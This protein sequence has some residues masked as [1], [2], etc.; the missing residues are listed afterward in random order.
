MQ[1]TAIIIVSYNTCYMM[2]ENIESIRATLEKGT[3]HIYVVDNASTDGIADWLKTE[4]MDSDDLSVACNS[5]NIGFPVA[6]N[7]GYRMVIEAGDIE[8]DIFLLNNDTR[9]CE[10]SLVNLQEALYSSDNIGAVGSISNYAGNN[11]QV[12]INFPLPYKYVEYGNNNNTKFNGNIK[13]EE[14]VRLSGFA[15][16]IKRKVWED[17]G[18]MDERFT[19]GYFED[20]D[21]SIKIQRLGKKL[22]LC[23]NSFI[24][25]AGSQSFSKLD[26]I[27]DLLVNNYAVFVKKYGFEILDYV[28]PNIEQINKIAYK[29][30]EAFTFLNL[31][32]GLGAQ[33]KYVNSKYKNVV[34]YGVETNNTLYEISKCTN[35]VYDSIS[36]LLDNNSDIKID[37][38]Y[39]TDESLPL[40]SENEIQAV[41]A[42]CSENCLIIPNNVID[43]SKIKLVIWDLDNTFWSGVL[44]EGD[45]AIDD[46]NIT[47]IKTLVDNGIMCSISSKNDE[48]TVL[49]KLSELGIEDYFVFNNINWDDKGEQIKQK[50]LD[51]NLRAE[52]TLFIDDELRNLEEVDFINEGIIA[53]DPQIIP[54]LIN[55]VSS[56]GGTDLEH[57]RLNQYKILEE[58]RDVE[59]SS[60]S[61]E[62]FLYDSEIYIEISGDC[63]SEIDRITELVV[64]SNQLNF[65]KIRDTKETIADL[66]S[67]N[68]IEKGII[69][70][71]D[72]FGD[73]GLIG[74]YCFDN[75]GLLRHFLFSCRVLG[76]GIEQ[77][78]YSMLGYPEINVSAPV[79]VTL[80][81]TETCNWI[82]TNLDEALK[83]QNKKDNE[84]GI[85]VL[86]KGPC[87]LDAV[88]SYLQG[89]N[90]TT[91]FNYVNDLG[92]VTTGQNHSVHI[93]ESSKYSKDEI[94]EYIKGVPFI[95][96]G[97]F[98]TSL[99]TEEYDVICLSLLPD[100]EAGLYRNKKTGFRIAFGSKNFDLTDTENIDGFINGSLQ[101]HGFS[102]TEEIIKSFSDEWE[103]EKYTPVEE[104]IKNLEHIYS[105]VPGNPDFILLLGSEIEYE[106]DNREFANLADRHR[107]VNSAIK[108]YA[109]EKERIRCIETT[110]YIKSQDD[111]ID[112]INHFSRNVY[113]DIATDVVASINDRVLA[114][115]RAKEPEKY[116]ALIMTVPNDY[117]R[118]EHLYKR[119]ISDL[120]AR[121]VR[122]IGNSEVGELVRKSGFGYKLTFTNENNILPFDDVHAV[123]K[124]A[125]SEIL[126]GR[127]LPRGITGWY[128]QQF[129]K[130]A[131]SK[132]CK[133]DYYLVWDGDTVPC[134]YFSMFKEGTNKPYFDLKSEYHEDYFIT[135]SKLLP[136]MG[137]VIRKSFISEHMLMNK[138][139]ML[140]LIDT[141]EANGNLKGETF[142]EKIIYAIEPEKLMS[143]SF[144]EFETYG[145]F[146]A[147]KHMDAY[148]LREWHSFRYGG[149]FFDSKT[150]DDE[151]FRWLSRDFGAISFEKDH[152]VREDH[153]NLFDNKEYQAKLSARQMLEAAQEEFLGDSFIETWEPILEGDIDNRKKLLFCIGI[154]ELFENENRI[155]SVVSGKLRVLNGHTNDIKVTVRLYP[156]NIEQWKETNACITEMVIRKAGKNLDVTTP[157]DELVSK[158]EAYYGGPSPYLYRF[159][160][161]D[162]PVMM[163]NTEVS[164]YE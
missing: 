52:N 47:L 129:L 155:V 138:E 142:Y 131:Y 103:F 139:Y 11:Q 128:Y 145:T 121:R 28:Y 93:V 19:P 152:E 56:L 151:D 6:C 85:K 23:N 51:M 7:Q 25:H 71:K 83:N 9:L 49:E 163:W 154:N 29:S 27:D 60:S 150:I 137:K 148:Q 54:E 40:Y 135:L 127:E 91:E 114:M 68:H 115:S 21:L 125:L 84:N 95:T 111:Y 22:L 67:D 76:M 2:Q 113:Y 161:L 158:N 65:T 58:K 156:N 107:E 64:R 80:N 43:F 38:I 159:M 146:V 79:A 136:G 82:R 30:D 123:M 149:D 144:S 119:L 133:D 120:P 26:N 130:M 66:I 53:S 69:R 18:G 90:I 126:N 15:M 10:K 41:I 122:F 44:S 74:F 1:K 96:Q 50:I 24:Y 108:K 134:K 37:V 147:I 116:D 20:D 4:S 89:G 55:Y 13:W 77:K 57:K 162:K 100:C 105:N 48:K 59:K 78:I 5:D 81:N 73:Y 143:N 3:Y 104:I 39:A 34:S 35:N 42:R 109:S 101:N 94:S 110:K 75:S 46:N 141:I 62:Q 112:C 102:F 36:A 164:N 86:L 98:G 140:E 88:G 160:M 14:R 118:V 12:D 132:V 72:K 70:A 106:G 124:D 16:L 31:G 8:S 61:R 117:K 97:D 99:F 63:D 157:D 153:R 33:I 87:D 45:V 92:F 32:C 17:V